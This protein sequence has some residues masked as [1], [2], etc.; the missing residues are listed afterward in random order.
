MEIE[1]KWLVDAARL[2]FD[3]GCFPHTGIRQT[4]VSFSPTIRLRSLDEGR[5]YVLTVKGASTPDGLAR[6]EHELPLTREQYEK[7]LLKAEGRTLEKV[8]YRIPDGDGVLEL[9]IF[10]GELKG[11]VLLEREFS[12]KEEALSYRAPDWAGREVTAEKTY[13][14]ARLAAAGL[15]AFC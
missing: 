10:S 8:R 6:E 1:R 15:P 14:N 12:S 3:P 7:L 4:Y 2:P 5:E 11:L 9:D 13:R